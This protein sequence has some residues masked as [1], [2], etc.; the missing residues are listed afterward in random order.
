MKPTLI[1]DR[2]GTLIAEP[3]D[4]Q[5]DD[6]RKLHFLPAMVRTLRMAVH[7]LGFRLI[8]VT[9]QDGLGTDAFPE[10]MFA[11]PQ[12]ILLDVLASEGI[13][14]D[15]VLIDR[16][17]P[18][19]GLPTRKPG[20]ALI[21]P[22]RPSIDPERSWVIGDRPTDV[23]FGQ[24]LG[25]RTIL[26]ADPSS[27]PMAEAAFAAA[28]ERATSW[29]AIG[30]LLRRHARRATID[31]R[32][33]ETTIA[34]WVGLDGTG[35]RRITTGL[36]FFDHMLEQLAVHGGIDIDIETV[37]D[38]HV[39]EHHTIEDT[40]LALG[41]ALRVALGDRRGIERYAFD[42]AMDEAQAR[43][44]LDLGNRPY[45]VWDVPLRQERVG[46]VPTVMM[47]HFFRSLADALRCTLHVAASGHNDHHVIEAVFKGVA[48]CLRQAVRRTGDDVP[49]SKGVLS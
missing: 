12:R 24:A 7:D 1:L 41:E 5:I 6:P 36:G 10:E 32:T 37:G 42:L 18:S 34:G 3:P 8:M 46:A 40:A 30:V 17:R 47:E 39:D 29:E 43:V 21:D 23:R 33:R 45:L 14:F 28:D 13:T 9:N 35:Y 26:L 15:A 19:D 27:K 31:R 49:S 4:E 38:L 48:R 16:S 25:L 44:A 22:Y 20:T 2:D 11:E